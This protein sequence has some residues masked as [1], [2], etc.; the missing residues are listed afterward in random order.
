MGIIIRLDSIPEP[1]Y[2]AT[3]FNDKIRFNVW[4]IATVIFSAKFWPLISRSTKSVIL[5][6]YTGLAWNWST[7]AK[8][9]FKPRDHISLKFKQ[10]NQTQANN[11]SNLHPNTWEPRKP[12]ERIEIFPKHSHF[13]KSRHKQDIKHPSKQLWTPFTVL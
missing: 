13:S 10:R 1:F 4:K 9:S 2:I 12:F 5:H 6:L 8:R 3:E 11:P 7:N